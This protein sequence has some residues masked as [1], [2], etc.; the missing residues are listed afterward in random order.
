M[1]DLHALTV[2][3]SI[4]TVLPPLFPVFSTL[5][6]LARSSLQLVIYVGAP[7]VNWPSPGKN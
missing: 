1:L 2:S 4:I 6:F 7:N 3:V 5:F